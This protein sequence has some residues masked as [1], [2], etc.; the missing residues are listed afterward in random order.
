MA[1]DYETFTV[2]FPEFAGAD[3]AQVNA[4]LAAADLEIDR[5]IWNAKGD[6]G[7]MY[8]AAHKLALS[9]YGNNAELVLKQPNPG[10]HGETV[11]GTHYDSLVRQCASGFRVA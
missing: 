9:P 7:Q 3:T 1:A 4:I 2:Q 10:P 5:E 11:Y 8:L 6:Q